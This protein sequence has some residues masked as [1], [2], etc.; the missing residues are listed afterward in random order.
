LTCD[1]RAKIRQFL[2]SKYKSVTVKKVMRILDGYKTISEFCASD[3]SGWLAKYRSARPNSSFDIGK[4][5]MRALEDVTA[6]VRDDRR[7]AEIARAAKEEQEKERLAKEEKEN[8]KFT[9]E[10]LKSLTSFMELCNIAAIDLKKIK[11]FLSII[12]AK[13]GTKEA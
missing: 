3:K 1:R 5:V 12:D 6:F 8:P 10:E 4:V 2:S 7:N 9:L 11:D 13:I